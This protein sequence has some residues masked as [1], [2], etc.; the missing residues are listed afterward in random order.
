MPAFNSSQTV[1]H[2]F[3]TIRMESLVHL[4]QFTPDEKSPCKTNRNYIFVYYAIDINH[5]YIIFNAIA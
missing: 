2:L 5:I 3:W 1:S 4:C